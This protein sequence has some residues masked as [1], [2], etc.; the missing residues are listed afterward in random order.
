MFLAGGR[1][2]YASQITNPPSF[3]L[4]PVQMD[5]QPSNPVERMLRVSDTERR[6]I[7]S[8]LGLLFGCRAVVVGTTDT[9][10]VCELCTPSWLDLVQDS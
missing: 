5:C 8:I 3:S 4:T 1:Y 6:Y 9:K 7:N 10:T 2:D